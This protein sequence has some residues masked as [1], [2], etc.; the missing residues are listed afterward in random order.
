M[1]VAKDGRLLTFLGL[2]GIAGAAAVRGSR[3][4]VRTSRAIRVEPESYR[5]EI[6]LENE[7]FPSSEGLLETIERS[8][9]EVDR[10]TNGMVDFQLYN[11]E[12]LLL[13]GGTADELDRL[14]DVLNTWIA[15][16]MDEISDW[17]LECSS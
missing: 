7:D 2:L 6:V 12:I 16:H 10:D 15:S 13:E 9:F 1:G 3:G 8:G 4:V 14:N 5:L 11:M 17:T